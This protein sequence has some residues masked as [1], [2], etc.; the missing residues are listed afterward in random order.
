[1]GLF[2]VGGGS[3]LPLR[4]SAITSKITHKQAVEVKNIM[5]TH[6]SLSQQD[7]L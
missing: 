6:T 2:E 3:L 4:E 1:M 7:V 5:H